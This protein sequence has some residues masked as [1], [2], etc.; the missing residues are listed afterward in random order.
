VWVEI[1]SCSRSRYSETVAAGTCTPEEEDKHD[2]RP[3][4]GP[5]QAGKEKGKVGS[6]ERTNCQ[7]KVN[8]GARGKEK[9][10]DIKISWQGGN[11]CS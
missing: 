6:Q 4:M 2:V 10:G 9:D 8:V 11:T 5:S 1:V 3:K 7:C